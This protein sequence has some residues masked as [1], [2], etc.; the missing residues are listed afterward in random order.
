MNGAMQATT[1]ARPIYRDA[2]GV[3]VELPSEPA[4]QTFYGMARSGGR[5]VEQLVRRYGPG[6]YVIEET[7]VVFPSEREGARV[8]G[9]KNLAAQ[10]R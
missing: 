4:L 9:A 1:P 10:G 6:R 2:R 8:I 3:L 5:L 7:G